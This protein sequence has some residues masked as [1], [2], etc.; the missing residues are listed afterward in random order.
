MNKESLKQVFVDCAFYGYVDGMTSVLAA[1]RTFGEATWLEALKN[2]ALGGNGE[3]VRFILNQFVVRKRDITLDTD[4][5]KTLDEKEPAIAREIDLCDRYVRA[6]KLRSKLKDY[7][8]DAP[9][10]PI[11]EFI[12]QKAQMYEF[13]E[14]AEE[15]GS[16]EAGKG[17]AVFAQADQFG[18][19]PPLRPGGRANDAQA[20]ENWLAQTKGG[21]S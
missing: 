17:E 3:V 12:D 19:P 6:E 7:G 4:W 16:G 13:I 21:K 10:V 18:K 2:A 8:I 20:V 14:T 1:D 15:Q 11:P 5:L 9:E